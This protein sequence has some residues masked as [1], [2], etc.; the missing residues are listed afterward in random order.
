MWKA[1][2]LPPS[3]EAT[4]AVDRVKHD[5]SLTG[6]PGRQT[7][8]RTTTD[9]VAEAA[10]AV[11][12]GYGA[13]TQRIGVPAAAAQEEGEEDASVFCEGVNIQTDPKSDR[14]RDTL[15]HRGYVTPQS[16]AVPV[17]LVGEHDL[18]TLCKYTEGGGML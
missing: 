7:K 1:K 6:R 5:H 2:T 12:A 15:R 10:A 9:A 18:C 8:R 4:R 17:A 13:P 16:G 3:G 14:F 11:A